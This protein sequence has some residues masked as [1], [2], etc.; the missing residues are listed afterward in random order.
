MSEP[1][2]E[3]F[4]LYLSSDHFG[5]KKLI[6]FLEGKLPLTSPS[7]FNDPFDT[8]HA[9]DYSNHNLEHTPE[10]QCA[11]D[12]KGW[13]EKSVQQVKRKEQERGWQKKYTGCCFAE[14]RDSLLMWTHYADSHKGVCLQ[15]KYD[16]D[17]KKLPAGCFFKKIRYSTHRPKP[18]ASRIS[19]FEETL[20]LTKSI[21]WMYEEEW[22]VVAPADP[23]SKSNEGF[24]G[25][26]GAS[27]FSLQK[28]YLGACYNEMVFTAD[29]F[30]AE[31]ILGKAV[32]T[33]VSTALTE[34][35]T[36]YPDPKKKPA[37]GQVILNVLDTL[38]V[39]EVEDT[40]KLGEHKRLV[41]QSILTELIKNFGMTERLKTSDDGRVGFE[42]FTIT[43]DVD[44]D[45]TDEEKE[46]FIHEVDARCPVSENLLNAT[47]IN[48]KPSS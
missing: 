34:F 33:E 9:F 11:I 12:E 26:I 29:T 46:A 30:W 3:Y 7:R 22:R 47:P 6:A 2:P 19:E 18:D 16:S 25:L 20:L 24:D 10:E 42:G 23:D 37:A 14:R 13:S 5:L 28:I 4:Y 17:P 21:D 41:A 45:M 27:P 40:V 43:V 44:A 31:K 32:V 39:F 48:V 8:K 38:R 15:F 35:S 1:M 36:V